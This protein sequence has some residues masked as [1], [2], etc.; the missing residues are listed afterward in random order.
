MTYIADLAEPGA[1]KSVGYLAQGHDYPQGHV[2]EE[3]FDRLVKLVTLHILTWMGYHNC[4]LDPCGSNQ[5]QPEFQYRGLVI[6]RKCSSDILVPDKGVV[7]M[8]PSLILHYI[9]C[10]HYLPPTSFLDA[11]RNCPEPGSKE[12]FVVVQKV[13]P[14]NI[15]PWP[16][17][18]S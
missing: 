9:R 13:W 8:A 18:W 1:I 10:H 14:T 12:Y 16:C 2:P 4:D 3:V 6:P 15:F 11:V 7:F 17:L 5:L